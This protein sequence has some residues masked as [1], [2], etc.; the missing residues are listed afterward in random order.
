[1]PVTHI[2]EDGTEVELFT[3]EELE[4]EKTARTQAEEKA[5]KLT[6]DLVKIKQ[7]HKGEIKRLADMTEAEK[8]ELTASQIQDRERIE[9]LEG[10][11]AKDLTNAKERLLNEAARKDPKILEK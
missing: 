3:P 10:G 9:Q 7:G 11:R 8:A 4:A 1:M 5:T 2:N 6:D